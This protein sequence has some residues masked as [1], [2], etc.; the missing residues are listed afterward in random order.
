MRKALLFTILIATTGVG[1]Q[2]LAET[3]LGYTDTPMLPSGK[4]HVHDPNR[5]K[6]PV[7]TPARPS[8][9]ARPRPRTR[10]SCSTA[11]IFP[12]GRGTKGRHSGPCTRITWRSNPIAD[13]F[14]PRKNS[15]ISN[16][17]WN[18]PSRP[19]RLTRATAGCFCREFTKL[20]VYNSDDNPIYADGVC[21]AL[22]GQSPPLV[23]ACKKP[24]QWQT[25]DI[26]FE[27]ARWN[28]KHELVR[29]AIV[30]VF[31]NGVLI[32]DK[33]PLLRPDG[34]PDT[35]Q[36]QTGIARDGTDRVAGSRRHR[37]LPQYMDSPYSGR[38]KALN[39][40]SYKWKYPRLC[41]VHGNVVGGIKVGRE[42]SARPGTSSHRLR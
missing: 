1:L 31:Q 34:P 37:A 33:Q 2:T 3:L 41:Q 22:Y 30:T 28:E 40:D 32:H 13:T 38:G 8:A 25:F 23:N 29:P 4:W 10:S 19:K 18:L 12:I 24:G 11:R 27:A 7:V 39:S 9:T 16:C 42:C 15:A 6:P 26:I 14:T 35:G 20:Q 36:L 5:P 21:G 17:T